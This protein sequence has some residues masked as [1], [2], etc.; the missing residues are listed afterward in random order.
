MPTI[1]Q[2]TI[3]EALHGLWQDGYVMRFVSKTAGL[4]ICGRYTVRWVLTADSDSVVLFCGD[5]FMKR[6][7]AVKLPLL[8]TPPSRSLFLREC[9]IYSLLSGVNEVQE[10]YHF[11]GPSEPMLHSVMELLSR[12][13]MA[14]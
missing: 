4:A 3:K 2:R 10:M 7:V 12:V 13:G 14:R 5:V 11:P 9:C 8:D 1:A 6:D